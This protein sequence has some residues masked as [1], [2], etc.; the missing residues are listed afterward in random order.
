MI[1]TGIA[2]ISSASILIRLTDA[3]PVT[4][5][6][7]RVTLAALLIA[8]WCAF[9]NRSTPLHWNGRVVALT[10][11]S[12]AFLA[13]HFIFWI[14]SLSLTSVASSAT[15]VSTAPLFVALF[16]FLFLNEKPSKKLQ[17]G[18]FC[19]AAGSALLA[20]HDYSFSAEA[21]TGDL[22]AVL[23]AIMASGYLIAGRFARQYLGL[24]AYTASAYGTAALILL[25]AS[26]LTETPLSG[27]SGKT[28]FFL[29]LLALI[30]QLIG[31]TAFNWTLRF[32]SPTRVAILVLG[33][34]LGAT[35][36][37]YLFLAETLTIGKFAGL[38]ILGSGILVSA[39]AMPSGKDSFDE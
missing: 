17:F 19:A 24:C 9:R 28:Y 33:E 30:P 38:A 13:L 7:Y 16:S 14:S 36:L 37:A 22:L 18:I 23:G 4:V 27:F 15:L 32:L 11:S 5:A 25:P 6:T 29:L 10:L 8:P 1:L 12:G 2:A 3:P 39:M 21:L 26:L 35:V 20:G 34:P 31:H